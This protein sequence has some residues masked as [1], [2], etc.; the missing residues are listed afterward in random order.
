[1]PSLQF[2]HILALNRQLDILLGIY[3]CTNFVDRDI[4]H[5]CKMSTI[6]VVH[7]KFCNWMSIIHT[8]PIEFTMF[9]SDKISSTD[10]LLI[11]RK[12]PKY[13]MCIKSKNFNKCSKEIN[14]FDINVLWYLSKYQ[15]GNPYN[16]LMLKD[17]QK[18]EYS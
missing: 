14:K 3:R 10:S 17:L 6:L 11:N 1:M 13:R 12:Y 9:H 18:E 16:N 2:E 4:N 15:R 5:P 8:D 7:C